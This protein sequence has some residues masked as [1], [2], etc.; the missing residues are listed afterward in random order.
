MKRIRPVAIVALLAT[1]LI[2]SCSKKAS[3]DEADVT[4]IYTTDV[5]GQLLNFDFLKQKPGTE[6]MSNI[7]SYVRQ[8]RKDNPNGTVLI[9][10][11]DLIEG[12]PSMY[13]YNY[14]NIRQE[15]LATR[16]LNYM[17]YDIVNLGN[18]DL[19]GGEAVY[20]DHLKSG[21]SMQLLSANAIDT[22]TDEP[23]FTPY[24]IIERKGYRIAILGLITP[25]VPLWI[26]LSKIPHL[27]FASMQESA[28]YWIPIIEEREQPDLII[29]LMHSGRE[30]IKLQNED[31]NDITD[32]AI[33]TARSVR[34]FDA[35][36]IGHDHLVM[37]D[38]IINNFG[39]TIPV[40]QPANHAKE[41]GRMD[42]HLTQNV[43]SNGHVRAEISM[44]RIVTAEIPADPD[45]DKTFRSEIDKINNFL[46]KSI[47]QP[48]AEMDGLKSLTGPSEIMDLIH[49][50]Q[51]SASYADISLA[52]CM[53]SFSKIQGGILSMRQLFSIYKYENQMTKMW[54]T[55]DE[56]HRFLEFGYGRQ[57]YQMTSASDH[58][59]NF[60]LK[61][62]GDTIMGRFGPELV[63][64]Q[65]NFTSAAGINYEVDVRKPAGHRVTIKSMADGSAFLPERRYDVVLS[66][67]QAAGGGGFLR[68]GLGWNTGEI[69]RH[70]IITTVKD[71][72]YFIQQYLQ[73]VSKGK[74]APQL[75]QW[76]VVPT[77][78]WAANCDRDAQLL[79]PYIK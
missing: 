2:I 8:C 70:T 69:E 7:M 37:T 33:I 65:Y 28:S 19:E 32:G 49:S 61:A 66:S 4:L 39:D 36:L 9:D 71:I 47:E 5:H 48:I 75:G 54:M 78:W 10:N 25:D 35:L 77:A 34:G 43:K 18:H 62:N 14:V 13:Y 42:L 44:Q 60:R 79:A 63:T 31:G 21:F 64:P 59:L 20:Y 3:R 73:G 74:N 17:G 72:R 58:L 50:V 12:C 27:R 40:L 45:Y 76:Q 26:P 1:I 55:G 51:L 46:D 38:T 23:M 41:I 6:S 67:Y 57:F 15:H 22:R 24:C 68:Q 11:G 30:E 16:V 53:S 56:I 29:G 52:S